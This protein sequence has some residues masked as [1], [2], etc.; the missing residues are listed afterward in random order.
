MK[1]WKLSITLGAVLALCV[2]VLF[3]E[4]HFK[5]TFIHFEGLEGPG[6]ISII[7]KPT[8]EAWR[9]HDIGGPSRLAILLTDSNSAWTG[10]AHGLKTIGVPFRI[11]NRLDVALKHSVILAYPVISGSTL[12]REELVHLRD[13]VAEGGT[14]VGVN[15]LGGGLENLFGFEEVVS[16]RRHDTLTWVPRN[17][18]FLKVFTHPRERTIRLGDGSRPDSL[19]GTNA[20]TNA[21]LPLA[22]YNDERTAI[23]QNTFGEGTS[24]AIGFDIGFYLLRSYNDRDEGAYVEYVNAYEP[25]ADVLLRFLAALY[26]T[27]QPAA[28]ILDT[29]PEG[30]DLSVLVTHDVD[31]AGSLLNSLHYASLERELGIKATYYMQT[32]YY[33][34]YYDKVFFDDNTR[35]LISKLVDMEMEIASHSVSHSL[36]FHQF[37]LGTGKEGYP[38]YQP[39]VLGPDNTIGGSVLGELRVSKYLLEAFSGQ[40]VVSFRPGYLSYPRVL[41]QSLEA[42][43]YRFS[44]SI[45]APNAMT[46]LPFRLNF[47]REYWVPTNVF[48]F[49]ITIEDEHPP[50]MD[51]RL[52]AS[53]E[54]AKTLASYGATCIV[55][56]HPD[57]LDHKFRFL[58]VFIPAVE[59]FSWFGTQKEFGQ[60]WAARDALQVDVF[61]EESGVSQIQLQAPEPIAGL[62]LLIPEGYRI[63]GPAQQSPSARPGNRWLLEAFQGELLL[64]MERE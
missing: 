11:T 52:D 58:E 36:H 20:Y 51:Q 21:K 45:T 41:P 9:D 42:T 46:H 56:I 24:F 26:R 30:K 37:P 17:Q 16:S 35:D 8:S 29:V 33:R 50:E 25:S 63:H 53:V 2:G 49:P 64:R 38:A 5:T 18:D 43:G 60:W 62:S 23:C 19:M 31:Y 22:R 12:S 40:S 28:V 55:L 14:L 57:V 15:V 39:R 1:P 34:D 6:E 59:S 10:L 13:F 48:E 44:S 3:L 32:K 61:P 7:Q 4:N 54:I 27:H 47:D